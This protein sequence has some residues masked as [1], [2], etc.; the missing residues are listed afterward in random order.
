MKVYTWKKAAHIYKVKI[1]ET[2]KRNKE[3]HI[4]RYA[5]IA[6]DWNAY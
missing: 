1:L 5:H 3:I 6:T 4:K 2:S